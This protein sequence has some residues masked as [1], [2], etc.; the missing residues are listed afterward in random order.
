MTFAKI[1]WKNETKKWINTSL[2]ICTITLSAC[3]G[4]ENPVQVYDGVKKPEREIVTLVM[5]HELKVEQLDGKS[6]DTPYIPEGQYQLHLLPG[7]HQIMVF[8]EEFWGD[9]S[10]GSIEVSDYFNFKITTTA[11]NYYIFEHTGPDDRLNADS[12]ESASDINIWVKQQGTGQNTQAVSRIA[13]GLIAG[14]TRPSSSNIKE[15][16]VETTTGP[17]TADTTI[18]PSTAT[19]PVLAT[20]DSTSTALAEQIIS[21]QDA[22]ERLKFWWK[23]ADDKQ[24]KEFQAWTWTDK[25]KPK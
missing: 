9:A 16:M 4:I 19:A 10:S 8:Y 6:L 18:T 21:Q 1:F 24:R 11:G 13:G 14:L 5:P 7:D 22:L 15:G 3:A 25:A 12:W 23:T 17:S 2:L 20:D